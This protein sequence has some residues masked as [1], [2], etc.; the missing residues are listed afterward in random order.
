MTERPAHDAR[1][2]LLRDGVAALRQGAAGRA[3]AMLTRFLAAAPGHASACAALALA[4]ASRSTE[5]AR[6]MAVRAR[7]LA[8]HQALTA[9]AL[10]SCLAFARSPAAMRVTVEAVALAPSDPAHWRKLAELALLESQAELCAGSLLAALMLGGQPAP[11][12]RTLAQIAASRVADSGRSEGAALL[13]RLAAAFPG[14]P[15]IACE[16]LACRR[17]SAPVTVAA[18]LSAMASERPDLTTPWLRLGQALGREDGRRAIAAMRRAAALSPASSGPQ[19]GLA[20]LH[21]LHVDLAA[22]HM[23][24]AFALDRS[25][26]AL[27]SHVAMLHYVVADIAELER[28]HAGAIAL[29]AAPG[30]LPTTA[31]RRRRDARIRVGYLGSKIFDHVL[32]RH[33]APLLQWHDS[34]RFEIFCYADQAGHDAS[35]LGRGAERHQWRY[36]AGWSD[37]HLCRTITADSLD[38]LVVVAAHFDR[39]RLQLLHHRLAPAQISYYDAGT[40]RMRHADYLIADRTLVPRSIEGHFTERVIRLPVYCTFAPPPEEVTGVPRSALPEGPGIAAFG[41]PMKFTESTLAIW[42]AALQSI[43]DARLVMRYRQIYESASMRDAVARRLVGAGIPLERVA[44]TSGARDSVEF[45]EAHRS[46]DIG[47]DTFPFSGMNTTFMSLL[48][49]VPV[50]TMGGGGMMGRQSAA[51]LAAVGRRHWV[52]SSRHDFGAIARRLLGDPERLAAERELLPT[53][54]RGTLCDGRRFVRHLERVYRSIARQ[55]A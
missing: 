12:T 30:P 21:W 32:T 16:R 23:E 27:Q 48:A 52:A 50:V 11:Q 36:V 49:G 44:F 25:S 14:D 38:I 20:R 31:T 54:A 46:V 5:D 3:A 29:W 2:G 7:L 22:R 9:S 37:R 34:N 40:S 35:S 17:S 1:D 10:A 6:R 13:D 26:A 28:R 33:L 55:R 45:L 41:H 43:P 15:H 19:D 39:C 47:F 51:L 8:P 4:S 18:E 42:S 24:A 53:L